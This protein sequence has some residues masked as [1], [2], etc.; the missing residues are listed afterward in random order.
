MK[1]SFFL[2]NSQ[3]IEKLQVF[4]RRCNS[5][6]MEV[7]SRLCFAGG[8]P[9]EAGVV[10][11]LMNYIT[12]RGA[13]QGAERGAAPM[14]TKQMNLFNENLDPT[15]VIRSVLLQLLLRSRYV[16]LL[17]NSWS[18]HENGKT[19]TVS[20]DHASM[21]PVRIFPTYNVLNLYIWRLCLASEWL[22]WG[23]HPSIPSSQ[24]V[25]CFRL[26]ALRVSYR[27]VN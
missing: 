15:P 6:L 10:T 14:R 25:G 27:F 23:S 3:Q 17:M 21:N 22:W 16:E 13:S 18:E 20:F 19:K 9:P 5:F 7:V 1:I 2:W 24:I 4:K 12:T 11:M 26:V 8:T